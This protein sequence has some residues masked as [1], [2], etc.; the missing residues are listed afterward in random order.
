MGI[1]RKKYQPKHLKTGVTK[2]AECPPM[3]VAEIEEPKE[4]P[5]DFKW[6]DKMIDEE[7]ARREAAENVC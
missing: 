2:A 7:M 3:P 6:L 1:F 5:L 4:R